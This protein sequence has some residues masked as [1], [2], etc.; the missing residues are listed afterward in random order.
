M[1]NPAKQGDFAA[2][3]RII[4]GALECNG[5][6][7]Y[8]SQ[9]KRVETYRRIRRCFGLGDPSRNPVC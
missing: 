1:A 3:T 2:T 7:G 5:G 9:L 8:N 6:S 4:N